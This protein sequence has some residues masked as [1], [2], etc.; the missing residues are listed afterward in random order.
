MYEPEAPWTKKAKKRG[1]RES[2]GGRRN[3]PQDTGTLNML[4]HIGS[5][6]QQSQ[7]LE[8]KKHRKI[9]CLS[10]DKGHNRDYSKDSGINLY[11]LSKA[12]V[13]I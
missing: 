7:C 11:Q 1:K 10:S 12:F 3:K 8:R 2:R 4:L 9:L 13:G 6:E 5:A